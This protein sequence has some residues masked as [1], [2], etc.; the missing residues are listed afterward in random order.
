MPQPTHNEI[1]EFLEQ[2]NAIE[3]VTDGI[4]L[5]DAMAAWE[6]L[7]TQ[8]TLSTQTVRKVHKILME[9]QDLDNRYKGRYRICPVY[10]GNHEAM[11]FRLIQE[12][13]KEWC[14]MMNQPASHSAIDNELEAKFRHVQYEKCH[15]FI[16]G[17]GRT[18]RMFMNWQRLRKLGLPLL[19]IHTGVEQYKYY[20]WFR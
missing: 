19:T 16:D 20:E 1:I 3:G 12:T 5:R 11:N 14:K 9:R 8:D 13:L 7:M 18:G 2:S 15:P 10:I 6:Y 4:S 17:N